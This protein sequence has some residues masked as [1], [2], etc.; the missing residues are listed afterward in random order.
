MSSHA[1]FLEGADDTHLPSRSSSD[2]NHGN[3]AD[4]IRVLTLSFAGVPNML[5][6]AGEAWVRFLGGSA[7]AAATAL[8]ALALWIVAPLVGAV[9]VMGR[10]D[11]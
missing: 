9:A 11:L 5:G 10:R 6:A 4:L 3:P 2:R 8:A 1:G 7:A